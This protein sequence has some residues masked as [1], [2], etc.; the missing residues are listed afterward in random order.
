MNKFRTNANVS[1][2][3]D[4]HTQSKS[5]TPKLKSLKSKVSALKESDGKSSKG[6]SGSA[7]KSASRN[8]SKN[9]AQKTAITYKNAGV[10]IEKGDEFVDWISRRSRKKSPHQ[11]KIVEAVGGFASLFRLPKGIKNP[12]IIS[13]TDGVGTK[14][15]LAVEVKHYEGIGQDLVA[16][17]VND[18]ICTGGSPLFFLDYLAMGKL[19]LDQAK[20]I[21]ASIKNACDH[22]DLAL[23][24]GETAEM[25]GVYANDDFDCAG[26]AVGVVDEKKRWGAVR[27]K[28]GD[29]LIALPSSGFHSNGYSLVRKI[30]ADETSA[31]KKT[32]LMPTFLYV[33]FLETLKAQF[34]IKAAAHITGSGVENIPRVIPADMYCDLNAWEF[35][36]LFKK[37]QIKAALNFDEM[38]RTFNCGVGFVLVV[39][40][41]DKERI[42]K[43]AKNYFSRQNVLMSPFDLGVIKKKKNKKDKDFVFK[44]SQQ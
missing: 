26:F 37:A 11:D 33:E 6:S 38:L 17:C 35:P 19:N 30:F 3:L 41:K 5:P 15:K 39:S 28:A 12:C 32:L 27:V 2:K 36:E 44:R 42:L 8:A 7:S 9:A 18:L 1:E 13:C 40:P 29:C 24:G 16:M 22:S 10:D 20:R 21:L 4:V 14:V 43:M 25:P 23:I 34:N 31:F